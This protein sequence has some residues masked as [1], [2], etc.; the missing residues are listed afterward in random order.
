MQ[1]VYVHHEEYVG[2]VAAADP[3]TAAAVDPLST[4]TADPLL[5]ID[6]VRRSLKVEQPNQDRKCLLRSVNTASANQLSCHA[7][8]SGVQEEP[9]IRVRKVLKS[10][11]CCPLLIIFTTTEAIT[12]GAWSCVDL[13][14]EPLGH[15]AEEFGTPG[16][17]PYATLPAPA[18]PVLPAA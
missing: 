1:V 10:W 3:A 8:I 4:A 13:Q 14:D 9:M 11:D 6:L 12:W 2:L 5:D 15:T 16:S 18:D 17:L 7:L